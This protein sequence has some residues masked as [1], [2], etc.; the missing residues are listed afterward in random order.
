MAKQATPDA[1]PA[2]P[3]A[4]MTDAEIL[5]METSFSN[6]VHAYLAHRNAP[7]KPGVARAPFNFK[8]FFAN[9][10]TVYNFIAPLISTFGGPKLPPIPAPP[11]GGT[12]PPAK[13]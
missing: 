5:E 13:A 11:G 1:A 9:A 6:F 10:V 4:S 12:T 7:A 8:N 2:D 3:L